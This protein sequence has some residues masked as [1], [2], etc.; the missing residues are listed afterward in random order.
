M[1]G[2][3]DGSDDGDDD[4]DG[5]WWGGLCGVDVGSRRRTT[6]TLKKISKRKIFLKIL[7][8][9]NPKVFVL[10]TGKPRGP[11]YHLPLFANHFSLFIS[12]HIHATWWDPERKRIKKRRQG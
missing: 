8:E 3:F 7:S 9:G 2:E 1:I 6:A 5:D 11:G 4:D 10:T 12:L